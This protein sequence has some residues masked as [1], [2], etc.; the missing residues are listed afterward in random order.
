MLEEDV[1]N[2]QVKRDIYAK[3]FQLN[4]PNLQLSILYKDIFIRKENRG[5]TQD[6]LEFIKQ[7]HK[8]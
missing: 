2:A 4:D 1:M 7:I 6:Q 3:S 5:K 8:H